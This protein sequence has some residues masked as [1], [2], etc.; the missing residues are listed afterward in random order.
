M[1]FLRCLDFVSFHLYF[2]ILTNTTKLHD[3]ILENYLGRIS[4]SRSVFTGFDV[5]VA[6][7]Y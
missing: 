4:C 7:K 6:A 1:G 5:N 2:N 3:F